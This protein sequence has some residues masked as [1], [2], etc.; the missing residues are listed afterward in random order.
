M[1]A[2]HHQQMGRLFIS[3]SLLL[4]LLLL[5]SF[6][7]SWAFLLPAGGKACRSVHSRPR[8]QQQ[9]PVAVVVAS[10]RPGMRLASAV[11]GAVDAGAAQR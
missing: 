9:R 1:A 8:S 7:S 5:V 4:L 11:G 3:S 6:T 10:G 2:A